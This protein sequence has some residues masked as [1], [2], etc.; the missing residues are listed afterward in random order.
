MNPLAIISLG[1][2]LL[3]SAGYLSVGGRLKKV[4][5]DFSSIRIHTIKWDYIKLYI[6]LL[7]ENPN[8]K[9]A[10]YQGLNGKIYYQGKELPYFK[11]SGVSVPLK[12]HEITKIS[13]VPAKINTLNLASQIIDIFLGTADTK[14]KIIANVKVDGIE[15]VAL[16][17]VKYIKFNKRGD[18]T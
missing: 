6:D 15:G 11:H 9:V 8:D 13:N 5:I 12:P 4:K 10:V 3:L 17:P 16:H 1:A 2:V 7:I 14:L 18:I